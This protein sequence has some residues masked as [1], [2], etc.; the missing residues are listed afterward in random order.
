MSGTDVLPFPHSTA[1]LPTIR[2]MAYLPK[3]ALMMS[4]YTYI[5]SVPII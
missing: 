3:S 4:S 2:R 1:R 5:L